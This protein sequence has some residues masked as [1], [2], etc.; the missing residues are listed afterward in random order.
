MSVW[1][2][3]D[4]INFVRN[5]LGITFRIICSTFFG[6]V[7]GV[8]ATQLAGSQLPSQGLNPDCGSECTKS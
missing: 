8:D 1:F 4:T 6:G 5:V 2:H 7:G 3:Y